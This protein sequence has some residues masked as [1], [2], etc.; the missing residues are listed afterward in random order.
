[1]RVLA[2]GDSLIKAEQDPGG[3]GWALRFAQ[4]LAEE[5]GGEPAFTN[6]GVSGDTVLGVLER[7]D[8]HL[9]AC[10]P[11]DLVIVGV[12]INDS[13]RRGDPPDRYEVD[14]DA[15]RAGCSR[16]MERLAGDASVERVAWAGLVPAVDEATRPFK[17]DKW[18]RRSDALEYA[19]IVREVVADHPTI[20]L[21]DFTAWWA[22]LSEPA[23][24]AL[25]PDGL[26]PGGMG[27]ARLAGVAQVTWAASAP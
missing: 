15:F 16:L 25:L 9:A 17:E 5:R 20:L 8:T 14:A 24:R 12:G 2:I 13:R 3:G 1:M 10:P 4:A 22:S 6:A 21:L 7:I 11:W 27:H 18:Y 26:H 19:R 23:R